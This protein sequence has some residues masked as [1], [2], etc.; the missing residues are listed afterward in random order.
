MRQL[1]PHSLE[2]AQLVIRQASRAEDLE[3]ILAHVAAEFVFVD[4]TLPLPHLIH[5]RMLIKIIHTLRMIGTGH[6]HAH[7]PPRIQYRVIINDSLHLFN[8][9]FLPQA[10]AQFD[11]VDCLG[12]AG[13]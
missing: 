2:I 5:L 9:Y 13:I 11:I 12:H 10:K 6:S 7:V 4:S 8:N 1:R 3:M